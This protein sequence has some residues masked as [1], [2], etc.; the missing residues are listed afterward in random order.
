MPTSTRP[1][2]TNASTASRPLQTGL[3]VTAVLAVLVVL[4]QFITAGQLFGKGGGPEEAHA[5]GAIVLHVVS[6]LAAVAAVLLWRRGEVPVWLAGLAVVVF[7]FGF[8]Q[9]ALGGFQTLY[10]HVP[11]AMILTA[12]TVWLAVAVLR[13]RA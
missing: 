2:S 6:G 13:R 1:T 11:G 3:K 5:A 4:W 9:A 8:L 12:G 7:G 10:V